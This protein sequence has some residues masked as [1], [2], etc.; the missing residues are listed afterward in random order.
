MGSLRPP[1]AVPKGR[2]RLPPTKCPRRKLLRREA[3]VGTR[4]G[5]QRRSQCSEVGRNLGDLRG[6]QRSGEALHDRVLA[7]P[8]LV[9]LEGA[10]QVI[11]VLSGK[12]RMYGS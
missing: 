12:R 11:L 5:L 4:L 8:V 10:H 3:G 2:S 9:L 1:S 6:F 7:A